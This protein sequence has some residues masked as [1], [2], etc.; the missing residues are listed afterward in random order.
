[1]AAKRVSPQSADKWEVRDA[2][3]TLARASEIKSNPK[4]MQEV[5]TMAKD[6]SKAAG[7][8]APKSSAK[9]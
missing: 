2:L 1:M 7:R 3:H 8:A 6:I 4:L 9:K 5:R